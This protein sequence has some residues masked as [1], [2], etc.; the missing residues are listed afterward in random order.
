MWNEL[1]IHLQRGNPYLIAIVCLTF[2]AVVF[3]IE[4][5]LM[6]SFVYNIK[7]AKFLSQLR[8]MIQAKDFDRAITLCKS[9]SSIAF[10]QIALRALEASENDPTTVK[11]VL[12]ESTLEFLPRIEVRVH[13]LPTLAT[14]ILLTGVLGTIDAI[15]D[16]FHSLAIL[17]TV[18]KQMT[19]AAGITG[20]LTYTVFSLLSCMLI[21]FCHQFIRGLATS[22]LDSI[23]L[24]VTSLHNQLVPAEIS[25]IATASG[26]QMNLDN[27]LYAT[28][29]TPE[30]KEEKI[31]P[32]IEE[33]TAASDE[34]FATPPVEDVKDE[35]EII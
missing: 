20:S 23:H 26:Q 17:D 2:L 22:L 28:I 25:Y 15:W 31:E 24:G 34:S 29:E 10:P 33:G 12:E 35:E 5:F 3:I 4:R 13:I 8:N 30:G 32:L 1:A 27:Q 16:S 6:L 11:G 21:L 18:Q 9:T 14:L 7:F 19:L